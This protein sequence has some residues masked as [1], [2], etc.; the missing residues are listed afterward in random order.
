MQHQDI[1]N[2][3]EDFT[4]TSEYETAVAALEEKENGLD[5]VFGM[6]EPILQKALTPTEYKYI[7]EYLLEK[8][9]KLSML[10]FEMGYNFSLMGGV[11]H[12]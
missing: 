4:S 2:L 8:Q 1:K 12:E 11:A 6:F 10:H 7:E 5:S 9:R 3:F